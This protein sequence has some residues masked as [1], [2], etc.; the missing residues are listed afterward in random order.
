MSYIQIID[1]EMYEQ[2]LTEDSDDDI[3]RP[4][5]MITTTLHM[6]RQTLLI[7]HEV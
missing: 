4:R 2:E 5:C 6:R 1:R 3:F 7:Y